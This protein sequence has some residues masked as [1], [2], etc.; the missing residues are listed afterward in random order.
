MI[1]Q[2]LD[3]STTRRFAFFDFDG[4]LTRS[5]TVLPFLKFCCKNHF[6]YYG[7]LLAHAP[8]LLGYIRG[9]VSNA[10][11]KEC[12]IGAFLNGWHVDDVQHQAEQFATH[13]LPKLLLPAGMAKL[14]QHQAQGDICVLVSA[15]P[16]WYLLPWA[17]QHGLAAVL[18][19]KMASVSG[20]LNGKI[21]G[22]NCH[23]AAKVRR[24]NATFGES[25]WQNS[26]A[27]SDAKVDLPMLQRASQGF[28]L[29][30]GQFLPI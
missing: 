27:Y 11:A 13:E 29:Q 14:A 4:T 3:S 5:D 2:N 18:A 15:S 10:D 23:D 1:L 25:C 21:E 28:L 9:H 17:K 16:D 22:E 26:V 20:C 6:L 24:I 8:T 19:T 30:N 12:V 7:K